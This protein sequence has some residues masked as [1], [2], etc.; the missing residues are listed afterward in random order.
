MS[1]KAI[2]SRLKKKKPTSAR[3]VANQCIEGSQKGRFSKI[4]AVMYKQQE[5][6]GSTVYGVG[7]IRKKFFSGYTS[8]SEDINQEIFVKL[9]I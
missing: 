2:W 3:G 8:L 5:M 4:L 6:Q 1:V 7:H 9:F